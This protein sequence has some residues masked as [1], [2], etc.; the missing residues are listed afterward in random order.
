MCSHEFRKFA[1]AP[2]KRAIAAF[3]DRLADAI[4]AEQAEH[5]D[6]AAA[7]GPRAERYYAVAM[8]LGAVVR[9]LR[10]TVDRARKARSGEG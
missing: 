2:I 10:A 3:A 1:S 4:E 6:K 9:A 5:A 8:T 7:E